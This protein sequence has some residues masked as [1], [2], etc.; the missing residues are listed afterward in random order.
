ML[1]MIKSLLGKGEKKAMG[2]CCGGHAQKAEEIK[3]AGGS[4][5]GGAGHHHAHAHTHEEEEDQ[6]APSGG[7]CG[8][9]HKH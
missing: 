2:G 3:K 6:T 9:H 7:C 8:G 1:E 4:C 5:C